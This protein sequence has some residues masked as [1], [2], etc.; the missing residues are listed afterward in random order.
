MRWDI[1]GPV[2]AWIVAMQAS[3][4]APVAAQGP[5]QSLRLAALQREA[6]A[7]DPRLREVELQDQQTGLRLRNIEVERLPAVSALG[8]TQFQSDVPT[9]PF[10]LVSPSAER[11]GSDAIPPAMVARR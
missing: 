10:T 4:A 2:L 8:Q 1:R 9:A 7:A 3:A 11:T 5:P 6:L